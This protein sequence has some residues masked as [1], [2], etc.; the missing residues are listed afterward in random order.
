[1]HA[2]FVSTLIADGAL[3]QFYGKGLGKTTHSASDADANLKWM[4]KY[5]PATQDYYG[6]C[7]DSEYCTCGVLGRT[8]IDTGS[9]GNGHSTKGFGLHTVEITKGDRPHGSMSAK[10]VEAH[11]TQ[12]IASIS[13]GSYDSFLDFN[14]GF[15]TSDLDP[16]ISVLSADGHKLIPLEWQDTQNNRT[17]YSFLVQMPGSMVVLEFMSAKQTLL[18]SPRYA[19]PHPRYVF[20]KGATPEST[21][22]VSGLS[23]ASSVGS[24]GQPQLYAVRIS[25]FS[26]DIGRDTEYYSEVLG[27][28][29]VA[30]PSSDG[31]KTMAVDFASQFPSGTSGNTPAYTQ[32]HL[33]QRDVGNTT[34]SLT[35]AGLEAVMNSCHDESIQSPT[36]GWNTWMDHHYCISGQSVRT[37]EEY[38]KGFE[39]LGYKYHVFTNKGGGVSFYAITP[40]GISVQITNPPSGGWTPPSDLPG[41]AGDLCGTGTGCPPSGAPS[42]MSPSQA[43]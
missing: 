4:L 31:V 40:N 41:A 35:V 25:H 9:S 42:F 38:V 14:T 36:C 3:G 29:T 20:A 17:Y 33:V 30:S 10:E 6:P 32:V 24:S 8:V 18:P 1:L 43:V 19:A 39:S 34:G 21:F 11:F 12:K 7:S 15:W 27:A 28:T 5:L 37:Q 26:S 13:S 22:G 23:H 2:A 16:Y